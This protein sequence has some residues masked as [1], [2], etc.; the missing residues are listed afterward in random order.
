MRMGMTWIEAP[1]DSFDREYTTFQ[2][3][4]SHAQDVHSNCLTCSSRSL[5]SDLTIQSSLDCSSCGKTL[6][7]LDG[8]IMDRQFTLGTPKDELMFLSLTPHDCA[9][10]QKRGLPSFELSCSE[11]TCTN[12]L[13][14]PLD[15]VVTVA[16][17]LRHGW[18]FSVFTHKSVPP[19]VDWT[20]YPAYH[21]SSEEA[22]GVASTVEDHWNPEFNP[23]TSGYFVQLSAPDQ[24]TLIGSDLFDPT[25]EAAEDRR[26]V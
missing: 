6:R 8:D 15:K 5:H 2:S 13:P 1:Q 19:L 20:S 7:D 4:A 12:P 17:R 9:Y 24:L 25:E 21:P 11:P 10:C 14:T 16:H 23:L 18:S 26:H 3:Y 22:W